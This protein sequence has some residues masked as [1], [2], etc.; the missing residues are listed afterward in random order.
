MLNLNVRSSSINL[1]R[2]NFFLFFLTSLLFDSD[3]SS[4]TKLVFVLISSLSAEKG[5]CWANNKY[6][7]GKL[8]LSVRQVS[9]SIKQLSKYLA[10]DNP[11]NEKRQICLDKNVH[12]V[13]QK[14]PTSLD[15]NVAHNT[16]K[17]TTSIKGVYDRYKTREQL[18]MPDLSAR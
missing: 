6:I 10:I 14:R 5:Y 16:I 8:G 2:T 9:R 7:G 15:K 11:T 12:A 3:L 4:T 1:L 13:R 17:K 18:G